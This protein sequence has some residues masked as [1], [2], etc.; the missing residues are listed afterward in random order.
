MASNDPFD[1]SD[2]E[3]T[4]IVPMPGGRGRSPPAPRLPDA[5]VSGF[6]PGTAAADGSSGLN[7]LVAAANPLLRLI[8]Q[9]RATI[10]HADPAALREQLIAALRN[11]E[12]QARAHGVES[13]KIRG[14]T[15]ALATLLDETIASTPWGSSGAWAQQSLLV[16]FHNE[17]WG[18]E[19]FF[20]LLARL[21]E[22]VP[23]NR[24]LLELLYACLAL[25]FEGRYRVIDNGR[26]Q[27]DAVRQRLAELLR[28]HAGEYERALSPHWQGKATTKKSDWAAAPLW[29]GVALIAVLLLGAFLL[30]RNQLRIASDPV[31]AQITSIRVKG[32]PPPEPLPAPK[33]RLAT[34]L[35]REIKDGLVGLREDNRSS[36]IT[37]RGDGLFG[38]GSATV[39]DQYV[40][41]LERIA[42]ALAAVPGRVVVLGHTD[43]QPINRAGRFPSNWDL[44]RERAKAVVADLAS[45]S[46]DS[47]RFSSEG[48]ADSE[49]IASNGTAEGRARNRR[50]EIVLYAPSAAPAK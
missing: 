38:S 30:A 22:N 6:D 31:Y 33:P 8:P 5:A 3:R 46:R 25:G 10:S 47:A 28:K 7:P 36:V 37:I 18:G 27:L 24:D 40:P 13:H 49:P 21:A 15:Y 20:Q 45:F 48:R 9:L 4:I 32:P 26:A 29:I 35:E 43:N 39:A 41:L 1:R 2:L 16:L 12:D 14:A 19:K 50:V 42:R 44:S 23:A 11:F 34:F 17:S